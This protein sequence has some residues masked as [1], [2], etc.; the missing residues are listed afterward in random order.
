VISV[1][2]YDTETFML[3]KCVVAYAS[4]VRTIFKMLFTR[5]TSYDF[6][7]FRRVGC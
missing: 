1:T 5:S 7:N 3:K 4:R 6:R 2:I